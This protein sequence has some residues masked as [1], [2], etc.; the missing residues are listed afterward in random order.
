[1]LAR[2]LAMTSVPGMTH[3]FTGRGLA[4]TR[5]A[6]RIDYRAPTITIT[7]GVF[8]SPS[9]GLRLAGTVDTA[10]GAIACRG[11]VVPSYYGLNT[12]A[13]RVPVLGHVLTGAKKEGLQVFEFDVRGTTASPKIK[14]DAVSSL[15]PG[16][17]RDLLKL[18]PRP[19]LPKFG[20]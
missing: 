13:G 5:L 20:R 10:G 7:D 4:V 8:E 12:L 19:A 16:A 11:S 6:A 15:A 17:V 18:L 3:L 1:V 2:L 14:V 9:L